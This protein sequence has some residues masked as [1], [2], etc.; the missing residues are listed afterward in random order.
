MF[1]KIA[2]AVLILIGG[3]L[4][5][6]SRSHPHRGWWGGVCLGLGFGALFFGGCG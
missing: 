6:S 4:T 1:L 2:A 5:A 3:M